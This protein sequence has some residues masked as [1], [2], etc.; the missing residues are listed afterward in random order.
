[1][2]GSL[3][4]FPVQLPPGET[5]GSS[6]HSRTRVLE[7]S[8]DQE[9]Q[10]VIV[11]PAALAR[12]P[13]ASPPGRFR[14]ARE[15]PRTRPASENLAKPQPEARRSPAPGSLANSTTDRRPDRSETNRAAS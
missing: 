13:Q 11:R 8:P 15:L 1:M 4:S 7:S 9:V 10:R 12:S 3:R 14:Q 5:R 6:P 2:G